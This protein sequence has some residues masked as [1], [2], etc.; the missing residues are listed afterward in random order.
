MNTFC[1]LQFL[2]EFH[3][4]PSNL[5]SC[6]F[7]CHYL[8][9]HGGTKILNQINLTTPITTHQRSDFYA[10]LTNLLALKYFLNNLDEV[11]KKR[12]TVFSES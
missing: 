3:R 9:N 7:Y 5:A 1:V 2:L 4:V 12:R 11:L 8:K 10:K 6:G